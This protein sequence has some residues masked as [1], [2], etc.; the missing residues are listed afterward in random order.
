M[1]MYVFIFL[2]YDSH[3]DESICRIILLVV[4]DMYLGQN[5]MPFLFM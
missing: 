1:Y 2:F 4:L 3:I 5:S